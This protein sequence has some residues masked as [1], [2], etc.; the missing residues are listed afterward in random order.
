VVSQKL[1]ETN[2][3]VI[4]G[5]DDRDD[6]LTV[7]FSSPFFLDIKFDGGAAGFDSLNIEGGDFDNVA[8]H[9]DGADSGVIELQKGLDTASI[10]YAGLEPIND[11]LDVDDR[12][13][14]F[15]GGDERIR[16]RADPNVAGNTLI[17]PDGGDTFESISFLNPNSSLTVI[18]G[19][20]SDAFILEQLDTGFTVT[21]DGGGGVADIDSIEVTRDADFT[22]TNT[23]IDVGSQ[24]ATL[25][26]MENA[27][28]SVATATNG[29]NFDISGW[30]RDASLTGGT[31][32]DTVEAAGSGD[33]TLTPSA[34][35]IGT[36]QNVTLSGFDDVVDQAELTGDDAE[37]E[38]SVSGWTGA[39]TLVGL[40]GDDT[41]DL[42]DTTSADFGTTTI[43][44]AAGGGNDIVDVVDAAGAL[45]VSTTSVTDDT[46]TDGSSTVTQGGAEFT[47]RIDATINPAAFNDALSDLETFVQELQT[48]GSNLE[49]L[50]NKLPLLDR[51]SDG[52]IADL[53]KLTDSIAELVEEASTS[54]TTFEALVD[55]I[56]NLLLD[57]GVQGDTLEVVATNQGY[58]ANADGDLALLLE[59]ALDADRA[60]GAID[61]DFGISAGN[62]GIGVEGS[63]A[64]SATLDMDLT[65]GFTNDLA[66]QPYV[67]DTGSIDLVL[68]EARATL[69][70]INLGFLALEVVSGDAILD[71]R[72]DISFV[73]PGPIGLDADPLS[74]TSLSISPLGADYFESTVGVEAPP[75]VNLGDGLLSAAGFSLSLPAGQNPF[76]DD[77]TGAIE[78]IIDISA[79]GANGRDIDLTKFSNI[80]ASEI[81]GM[82][83]EI[84]DLLGKIAGSQFLEIGIPF[85]ELDVGDILNLGGSYKETVL[86]PLFVSGDSLRPDNNEDG[87]IDAKDL[88]FGSIQELVERL[89]NVL[90][91]NNTGLS[92]LAVF[93]SGV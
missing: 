30:T 24:S 90:D 86:D 51:E 61:L 13:I 70:T 39:A 19:D 91:P 27:D 59:L 41:Y 47:E 63:L 57:A 28:L 62:R 55:E 52:G 17:E 22:L 15:D 74:V 12:V 65:L 6:T 50:N 58:Q 42:G 23:S 73:G 92:L 21:L 36:T 77:T 78:P 5:V 88:T 89:E 18:A 10:E 34:L 71:G 35:D 80:S 31:G 38:F 83:G 44:E 48:A 32:A 72:I 20:G 33:L 79:I 7:D 4:E 85:T 67:L 76:G 84:A 68:N 40:G 45:T 37:N 53:V 1:D 46:I 49:A 54:Q 26:G 11:N 29:Q 87:Q 75:G 56:N 93:D 9:A 14:T 60:T 16:L 43:V 8:Y 25:V 66:D 82:L 2:E 64:I 69:D 3:I 81:I